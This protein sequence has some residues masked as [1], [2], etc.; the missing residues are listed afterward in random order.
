MLRLILG[1]A[2]TGKTAAV[3]DEIR[4]GVLAGRTG[5]I[6]LVPEQYSHEAE[7][8][9]CAACGDSL[10]LYAEVLSFTSLAR[11]LR[12]QRGG[13]AAAMLDQG[14]RLLCMALALDALGR[15]LEVY[16]EAAR[17][18]ELQSLLLSAV[19]ELKAACV[20]PAMLQEAAEEQGGALGAK[21][22][23]LAL[24]LE[25]YDAIVAQGR[26]DPADRLTVLAQQIAEG[27]LEPGCR[28]YVDGFVD[29][30]RQEQAVLEAMLRRGLELCVCLTLDALDGDGEVYALS[31]I[32]G[33]R[34]RRAAGEAGQEVTVSELADSSRPE[35]L[36]FFADRMFRW[37]RE[38]YEGG[39]V[40]LSLRSA[41]SISAECEY[42]AAQALRLVREQ[43]CRWRDIA[44]AVRGFDSYRASLETAFR[45]YGVPLFTA[46]RTDLLTK[47]LPSLIALAYDI[48]Q[49]GW[50]SEDVISLLR[51]GLTGFSPDECDLLCGY[52]FLWQLRGSAW[53]RPG[54]WRQHPEG[55]DKQYDE[56]SEEKLRE[57]NRLRRLLAAPLLRFQRRSR[58]AATALAQAGALA[59]LLEE[60]A[61]PQQ[62]ESRAAQLE[63]AGEKELAAELGQLWDIVTGALEQCAAILG[64]TPMDAAR[65]GRLFTRMLSQYSVGLIPISLDR[66]SAG[67]FDR[68]RRRSIRHL[69]VLGCSDDR[70]PPADEGSGVFSNEERERLQ[71]LG[72]DL[73]G[74]EGELWREFS[75]IYN[76][77]TLP[78]ESLSLSYPLCGA[79]GAELHPAFVLNRAKAIFDLPVR[80][81]DTEL[82]R[83]SAP[84]PA[85]TLAAHAVSGGGQRAAAAAAYFR[86][87]Q[88]ERFAR[89]EQAAVRSR[90]QLSPASVEALYGR[91][92]HLSAS[93]IDKFASCRFAY[94]CQYGLK[95][96]PHEPAGFTPP[97]VGTFMHYV[98]EH[99]AREVARRGGFGKVSDE[100][101]TALADGF[102]DAYIHE[103]LNDMQEKSGRFVHLFGRLRQDVHQIIADTAAELRRSDF[104]PLDFELDFSKATEIRPI[105]LGEGEDALRLSGIADRIDGWLHEGKLYLR[106]VDYKT[107]RK[108]FSLSDVCYGMSL[109]MLLYL[110]ALEASGEERYAHP[111]VPAG[112]MYVPAR[113]VLLAAD[114]DIDEAEAESKRLKELRRS[115]FVLNESELIEAWERGADKRFIPMR[116]SNRADA[117]EPLLSA[118]RIGQLAQHVRFCLGEMARELHRGSIAADP[119]YR[120][121]KEDACL[122]CDYYAACQF[123]DGENGESYRYLP[124]LKDGQ[125]WETIEKELET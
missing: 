44:V 17:R 70:L 95:V 53:E 92:L 109:Q 81:L 83:L 26:A 34:L 18:P 31:R 29:F 58:E 110:F 21:L 105:M 122:N 75:L 88:P 48:T 32:A 12:Q 35:A 72:F 7:R 74:G 51:T 85:L 23:D 91:R 101:L 93:R 80:P 41:D 40:P 49:T 111:V 4:Q 115:G 84:A 78:S 30:T 46:Q 57:I 11:K 108:A 120:S 66:V 69:I 61:L 73:G 96:K 99:T 123:A 55:Y 60:L 22:R 65:F 14:G 5:Q 121:Q 104:V 90:G 8:E 50:E 24:V 38:R 86:A 76:T 36:R 52:I 112:I 42:A 3:I 39:E 59:A 2:G 16:P 63:E 54:D 13:G 118:E 27:G 79:D 125:V 25:S 1:K 103:K 47:P 98:L 33:N 94:F 28:V 67:D 15:R 43:G 56:Q 89:L 102:V 113:N 124:H 62:L 106:V 19:D 37:T 119:Y 117:A 82:L 97:E 64:E 77:L 100:E 107:G 71:A 6:L 114:E 45:H 9:L 68:M 10:S 87:R 20:S 116:V